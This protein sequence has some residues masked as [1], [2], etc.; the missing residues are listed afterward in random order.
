MSQ[1]EEILKEIKDEDQKTK[2]PLNRR[3]LVIEGLYVNTGSMSNRQTCPDRDRPCTSAP[4]HGV[5]GEVLLP[6]SVGR[7][8]RNWSTW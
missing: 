6:H 3:F 4:D 2:R 5:E 8:L 1:L 7:Q